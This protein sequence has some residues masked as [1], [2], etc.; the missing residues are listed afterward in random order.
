MKKSPAH[1]SGFVPLII[2]AVI[3]LTATG[4]VASNVKVTST[5]DSNIKGVF[6][7]KGD[8]SSNE[9]SD[10]DK[11]GENE[12]EDVKQEEEKQQEEAKKI[13]ERKSEDV[14]KASEFNSSSSSTSNSLKSSSKTKPSSLDVS[15]KQKESEL[16]N[17]DEDIDENE[18]E[19]EIENETDDDSIS[20]D[21]ESEIET[22]FEDHTTKEKFK[23]K[24][25]NGKMEIEMVDKDGQTLKVVQKDNQLFRIKT[26]SES[27]ETELDFESE[28]EHF[29]FTANGV[30]AL[31]QLPISINEETS[32]LVVTTPAG[33]KI[34]TILPDE[35]LQILRNSLL[36]SSVE[37]IQLVQNGE[38]ITFKVN[39][40]KQGKLFG[41]IPVSADVESEVNAETGEALTVSQPIWFRLLS[42]LIN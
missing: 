33:E 37:K 3:A 14:K 40:K 9:G 32:S 26:S 13:E 29:K 18:I 35:A 38:N 8:D 17:E 24:L 1:N 20:E 42:G 23:F 28:G 41:F 39:G 36:I 27:A 19:S 31:T 7:A 5:L 15:S 6:I 34:V 10:E 21:N 22:E 12:E 30:T 25:H 16:E 4:A 11:S 2:L